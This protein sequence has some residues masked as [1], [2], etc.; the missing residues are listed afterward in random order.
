MEGTET[1]RVIS[2]DGI[3]L[4]CEHCLSKL[5]QCHLNIEGIPWGQETN[6]MEYM[7]WSGDKWAMEREEREGSGST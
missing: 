3:E 7:A 4:P 6:W 2:V 1:G 5:H